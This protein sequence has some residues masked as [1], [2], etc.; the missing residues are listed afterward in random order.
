MALVIETFNNKT[1]RGSAFFK[2]VGHPLCLEQ[3]RKIVD[4]IKCSKRVAAFDSLQTLSVFS[5]MYPAINSRFCAVYAQDISRFGDVLQG[6]SI[7][8]ITDFP[9]DNIELLFVPIFDAEFIVRQISHIVPTS[10]EIITLD[11]MKL[12]ENFLADTRH[13][14]NPINFATNLLFFREVPNAHTR[15]VTANYWSAYGAQDPFVWGRVFDGEGNVLTDFEKKLGS[16]HEVLYIDSAEL[17]REFN[18]PDFCGQ[19][20]L[21]IAR[22]AGHDIVKYVA[23]SYG[24]V[25]GD[26]P[27]TELSCTHDANSWPA[28]FYAGVPAPE[29]GDKVV[30]WVQNSHPVAIPANA[31]GANLMGSDNI[32]TFSEEI[33]PFATRAIDLNA[34]LP[35]AK[36]P[37]QIEIRAGRHFVRPRY[38]VINHAHRRRINHANVER[39]DLLADK[40]LPNIKQYCG[41]G[42]ILPAP[43]L[44]RSQYISTCLPTPMSTNCKTLPIAATVY[45]ANGNE[46]ARKFLGCLPRNHQMLLDLSELAV[47]LDEDAC[48][49]V[50]LTYDFSDGGDGDGWLHALFR[51]TNRQS[52][53]MAET[54][55]G[56]HMFNHLLTYKDEPQSYKGSPPGLTTRLFLRVSSPPFIT[57]CNLIYPVGMKWHEKSETHLELRNSHGVAL[58]EKIIHIPS[59]GS[60]AFRCE[61]IF[62]LDVLQEAGALSY[63]VI[64]DSTCRLFGYHGVT[65]DDAFALDHMFGF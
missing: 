62:P 48:G 9:N 26:I 57:F 40:D 15:L 6:C 13:Y 23:D 53:H 7:V 34:L 1:G 20:F 25:S 14:L 61:A 45:D 43:I 18:L 31:I 8:P 2:A 55:F 24:D 38:E 56:A 59:G 30:L 4:K 39:T 37:A 41:K 60:Y 63:V 44:P 54:S 46:L 27:T 47:G 32:S 12:P 5:A 52:G 49:H 17:K 3:A 19:V 10:C 58:L 35:Q 21:H 28:D 29:K 65:K 50:E 11:S 51:Y 16:A 22:A 64:K 42:Y 36:W 33:P